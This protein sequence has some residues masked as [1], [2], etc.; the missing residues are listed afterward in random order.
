[1]RRLGSKR[2]IILLFFLATIF[3]VHYFGLIKYITIE[4]IKEN[5]YVLQKFISEHYFYSV[6]V[7]IVILTF[8]TSLAFPVA[9]LMTMIGGF[10][11]GTF[12]GAFYAT[13]GATIGSSVAF[14]LIRYLIGSWLQSRFGQKMHAFNR[15]VKK[16][17]Y[18]YLLSVHFVSVIPLFI[19]NILSA[20]TNVSFWTF[21]WTTGV[22]IF[23][24]S[25]V[26]SFAGKQLATIDS[27][28]DIFS[29]RILLAFLLLAILAALPVV[30]KKM[31][32]NK[33][34]TEYV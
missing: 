22:G 17:G 27:I 12:L 28:G 2:I 19:I 23:P 10:L 30:V 24:G 21:V 29:Y 8:L 18:S 33:N 26:Y 9:V 25:L 31:L 20:L 3:F 14:L 16:H 5:T 7:Y 32:K 13:I 15:E 11:F 1:M 6:V 4:S 34:R